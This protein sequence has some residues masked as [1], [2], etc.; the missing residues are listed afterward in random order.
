MDGGYEKLF[1]ENSVLMLHMP[2]PFKEI[3]DTLQELADGG[4]GGGC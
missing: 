3:H 1:A 2:R 4:A